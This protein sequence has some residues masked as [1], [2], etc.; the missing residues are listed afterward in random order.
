MLPLEKRAG[1]PDSVALL[2]HSGRLLVK[3]DAVLHALAGIGGG[4][5][6]LGGA[7]RLIPRAV[8]DTA[9]DAMAR[10]RKRF[11]VAPQQTCPMLPPALRGRFH[12]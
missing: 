6:W 1:L 12:L 11:F 2:T 5:K 10:I 9:Y 8:R 7:L 3:S 4:W